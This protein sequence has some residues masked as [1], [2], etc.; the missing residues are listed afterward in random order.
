VI[1]YKGI[2]LAGGSGT[3]LRPITSAVSKQLLPIYDKP[4]IY[5]SLSVLMLSGIREIL[6]IS[7]PHDIEQYKKLLGDG[8][9]FGIS[10]DYKIQKKPEG[11]GQAFHLGESF[12]GQSN[13]ALIL[14]DNLFYGHN[15]SKILKEAQN[16]DNGATIFGYQVS[17]PHRFGVVE[18]D[19]NNKVLS[20]EEKPSKPR[21]NFAITGL[22]FYDNDVIEISKSLI[23]SERGEYEI[24]DLNN[25]YL[26]DNN[27]DVEIMNRGY[28]WLDTGTHDSLIEASSFVATLQKRQGLVIACPEEIALQKN[29]ITKSDLIYLAQPLLKSS[30]GKYLLKIAN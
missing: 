15:F 27:L 22:Y 17:D 13:V 1:R 21:S 10:I 20:I 19:K 2:I 28:T 7:S 5:Y 29:W 23:P 14:G 8:S 30:Y 24:T 11:L 3:R 4:M 26:Y 9:N 18:F 6:L 12:I 25:L 16:L